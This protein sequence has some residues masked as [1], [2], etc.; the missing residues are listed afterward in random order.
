[1][2]GPLWRCNLAIP[3][4]EIACTRS[5]SVGSTYRRFRVVVGGGFEPPKAEPMRLQR[6]P[7]GHSG[8]PPWNGANG[9][10]GP[11]PAQPRALACR[12]QLSLWG[13]KEPGVAE[14]SFDVVA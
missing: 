8:I 11:I 5:L 9:R 12:A 1:M 7:F 6:I 13:E 14:S 4:T 2:D 10:R 3:A